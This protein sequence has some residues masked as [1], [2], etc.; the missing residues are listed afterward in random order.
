MA[1]SYKKVLEI[2]ETNVEAQQELRL[3]AMRRDK[4]KGRKKSWFK[5]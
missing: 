2:D 1:K 4:E 3:E 5:G